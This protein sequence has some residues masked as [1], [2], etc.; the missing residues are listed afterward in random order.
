MSRVDSHKESSMTSH[1]PVA[2]KPLG[3]GLSIYLCLFTF[4]CIAFGSE[5]GSSDFGDKFDDLVQKSCISCHDSSTDTKLDFTKLGKDLDQADAMRKWIHVFDRVSRGEMPPPDEVQPSAQLRSEALLELESNLKRA[6]LSKQ[7]KVGRVPSRRLSRGEYEHTLHDLLNIGGDLA[8]Y[9]PPENQS[10]SFDVVAT[11]QDMSSVHIRGFMM[12]ADRAIDEA[13]ELGKKPPMAKRKIDYLNSRYIQMW[14]D[15]PIRRGGG[16]IFKTEKDVVTFRGENYVFRS[17][18][19]GYRPP[20]AG[21]YRVSIKAAPHQPRSSITL[22]FRRQND[23][24]GESKLIEAWDLTGEDYRNVSTVTYLR[25]DDYFYVSAD[26]LEPALDGK[27]IYNSQ[28]ASNFSG[29]GVKIRSV[30]IEGPLESMWPPERTQDLFAGVSWT[31][32]DRA[33]RSNRS[34]RSKRFFEPQLSNKSAEHMRAIVARLAPLAFRRKVETQE[35]EALTELG[36]I[37]LSKGRGMVEAVRVPIRA[38]LISPSTMFLSGD[39]GQLNQEDLASRLSYFLWRSVPDKELTQL[40]S[41]GKLSD[42]KTL[43][44]QVDR[45]LD[46]PKSQRFVNTFLD[47]W[48]NL[49]L[50]DSTTPDF[51]LYPEYDDILRRA[52]LA[53]TRGFFSHLIEKDLGAGN[54]IDSDFTFLNRRLAEHYGIDGVVGEQMRKV[55]LEPQS[56]RG[57]ILTHASIAKITANGTVTTPV[58]RGNFVLTHLLG[59]PPN[60]PPPNIGSIEPDTR[61]ATTIR[62]TLAKHQSLESCAACH[63]QIDPPGFAME[64]FDPIGNFRTRYRNSRGVKRD[65]PVGLRFLHKDYDLGRRVD[66]SGVTSDGKS[67]RGIRDY[68]SILKGSTDQVARN[69]VSKLIEF[70]TGGEIEFADREQIEKILQETKSDGF[71]VRTLIK[72]IVSSRIFRNR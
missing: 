26:E 25:P 37:E 43:L 59:L 20:V 71:P 57:G 44:A 32:V 60:P 17:D 33:N 21:R 56:A 42:T 61:G 55:I 12:A 40:A 11:S 30:T 69:L 67:F 8:K 7:T 58:K 63:R 14:V 22:S 68:K 48:L 45:M 35:I 50:I 1:S 38:I 15:R 65:A 64:V 5:T 13:I 9:L 6:S 3:M 4:P 52:M 19:N 41:S 46:D 23:K 27:V 47:Q 54:L 53:E 49:K 2:A 31:A 51:Y 66:P 24:Q 70:S 10:G 28:P 34:K 62:E 18:S 16:T 72:Q 36:K 39:A 29:E